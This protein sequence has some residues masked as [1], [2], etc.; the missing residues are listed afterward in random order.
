MWMLGG[1]CVCC[2]AVKVDSVEGWVVA[3]EQM[4]RAQ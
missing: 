2:E 1:V 3:A 4:D